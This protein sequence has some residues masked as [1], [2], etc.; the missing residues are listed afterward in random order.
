MAL[1][2]GWAGRGWWAGPVDAD[3]PPS[4]CLIIVMRVLP[5][6]SS[7]KSTL[8]ALIAMATAKS[9]ISLRTLTG[10]RVHGAYVF[11]RNGKPSS[12]SPVAA[13]GS[14]RTCWAGSIG[15]VAESEITC[16]RCRKLLFLG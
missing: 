6:L 7:V 12:T 1:E 9:L 13:C 4:R 10:L 15:S 8:M 14:G 3:F 16:Q 5:V 2:F 11:T